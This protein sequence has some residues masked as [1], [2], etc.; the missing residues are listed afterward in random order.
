MTFSSIEHSVNGYSFNKLSI[1]H[2][3]PNESS[4]F[5]TKFYSNLESSNLNAL[6]N[7]IK[8]TTAKNIKVC[9]LKGMISTDQG[10]EY[11]PYND[12]FMTSIRHIM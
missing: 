6:E 7:K 5:V 9:S 12:R 3:I 1:Y 11:L 8:Q 2:Y 10:T 4:I